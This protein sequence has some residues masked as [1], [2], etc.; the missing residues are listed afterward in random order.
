MPEGVVN[1]GHRAMLLNGS[2]RDGEHETVVEEASVGTG[3]VQP[4]A[5]PEVRAS[6][7]LSPADQTGER[8]SECKSLLA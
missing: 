5:S 2:I 4:T 3:A 6:K 1:H 8:W 7:P